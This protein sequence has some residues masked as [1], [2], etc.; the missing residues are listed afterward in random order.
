MLALLS[1]V[2]VEKRLA[3]GL[4]REFTVIQPQWT[5]LMATVEP[6]CRECY[7]R[8]PPYT[9]MNLKR[10]AA[11]KQTRSIAWLPLPR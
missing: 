10:Q 7:Q 6:H 2:R 5:G 11:R 9:R 4:H 8:I 3:R 1:F